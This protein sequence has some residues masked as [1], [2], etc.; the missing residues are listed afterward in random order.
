V[1]QNETQY[2]EQNPCI[3]NTTGRIDTYSDPF[4]HHVY[5]SH[6]HYVRSSSGLDHPT[7]AADQVTF[8]YDKE[9]QHRHQYV[10]DPQHCFDM[11][12]TEFGHQSYE[13]NEHYT[14]DNFGLDHPP[15]RKYSTHSYQPHIQ[16]LCD[17]TNPNRSLPVENS[18]GQ[19]LALDDAKVVN[20][21]NNPHSLSSSFNDSF[22]EFVPSPAM[23]D[24]K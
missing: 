7:P 23:F 9:S 22:L 8:H 1:N 3:R 10:H 21:P 24:E 4:E 2:Q 18:F 16:T 13:S 6:D 14:H 20:T 5:K 19:L 12:G 15:H 11:H 17:E